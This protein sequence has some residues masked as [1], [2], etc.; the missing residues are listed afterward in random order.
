M[1]PKKYLDTVSGVRLAKA[2]GVHPVTIS[3]WKRCASFPAS[4]RIPSLAVALGVEEAELA[5]AIAVARTQ[6][7]EADGRADP[8]PAG[9]GS[10]VASGSVHA[11]DL[12]PEAAHV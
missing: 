10:A 8:R 11:A 4:T 3:G 6:R 12:T 5:E 7:A 9:D 2:V 1:W